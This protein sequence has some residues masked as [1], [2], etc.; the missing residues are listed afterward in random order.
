MNKGTDILQ[1]SQDLAIPMSI[2]GYVSIIRRSRGQLR[3]V[4]YLPNTVIPPFF[5]LQKSY[6][7]LSQRGPITADC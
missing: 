1:I 5:L 6:L 7:F 3:I 4:Q 2:S